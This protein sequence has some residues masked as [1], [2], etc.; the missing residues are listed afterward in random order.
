MITFP[1]VFE[2]LAAVIVALSDRDLYEHPWMI[3]EPQ[4]ASSD[5]TPSYCCRAVSLL[6]HARPASSTPG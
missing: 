6:E 4:G 5:G 2:Y 3:E 1:E